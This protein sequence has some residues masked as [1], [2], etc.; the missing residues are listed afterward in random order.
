MILAVDAPVTWHPSGHVVQVI[1]FNFNIKKPFVACYDTVSNVVLVAF[2][3]AF[4]IIISIGLHLDL[5]ILGY[6]HLFM[7]QPEYVNLFDTN[8]RNHPCSF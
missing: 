6:L 2:K 8:L 4:Y 5:A 7:G 3:N 1:F